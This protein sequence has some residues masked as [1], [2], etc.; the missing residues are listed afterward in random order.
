MVTRGL[1][2]PAGWYLL[3]RSVG[4]A[5]RHLRLG[6]Y[7]SLACLIQAKDDLTVG[8]ATHSD[9]LGLPAEDPRARQ[10]LLD[11]AQTLL[12]AGST[13]RAAGDALG[14]P[15]STLR[16]WLREAGIVVGADGT[17]TGNPKTKPTSTPPVTITGS[18]TKPPVS[19]LNELTQVGQIT[20][21]AWETATTGPPHAPTFTVTV[22]T[23]TDN[24]PISVCG[25]GPTK[26]IAKTQAA[27]QLLTHLG[28]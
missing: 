22:T 28:S 27:Q 2:V 20:S 18:H 14:V 11:I 16:H 8:A 1:W 21:P 26:T 4:G 12:H 19:V 7:C 5:G 25:S 17:L 3:E 24:G 9:R 23:T 10:R 6:L 13:I 15:T